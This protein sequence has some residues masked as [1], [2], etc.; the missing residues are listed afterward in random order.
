MD[1]TAANA[2][3]KP[4]TYN[5]DLSTLPAALL[6]LC[7]MLRWVIWRWVMNGSD[8]WTKPPFQAQHPRRMARNN[9]SETWSSHAT[10]AEA[11]KAGEG[12]GIGFVLTDTDFAA[13][14]LDH[15]RDPTTGKVDDWAQAIIEQAP[16]AYCE[17]TVSGEDY[18]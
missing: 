17:T 8:K 4:Q 10:A 12:D 16:G 2:G 13:I 3:S 7:T 6:L 18:V 11:V 5:G 9:A 1:A 14:D 15:C